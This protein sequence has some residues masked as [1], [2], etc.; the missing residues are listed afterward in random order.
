MRK[1]VTG[2]TPAHPIHSVDNAFAVLRLIA[3]GQRVRVGEVAKELN[4]SASTTS[5]LFAMLEYHG[6]A[7]KDEGARG[8]RVGS[9]FQDIGYKVL[10][11]AGMTAIVRPFLDDL[12]RRSTETVHLTRLQ[13][14]NVVFVNAAEG[15]DPEAVCGRTGA[16]LPAH[17]TAV[18][19]VL[20]ASLGQDDFIAAVGSERLQRWTPRSI[21]SRTDLE[22]QLNRVRSDGY[23]VNCGECERDVC[24]VAV[25]VRD[26]LGTLHAAMS[27][28]IPSAR[29]NMGLTSNLV[30]QLHLTA[31]AMRN[32]LR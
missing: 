22:R 28:S 27:I 15:S 26:R 29:F 4:L 9:A 13:A 32:R 24:A 23:A 1:R 31:S 8:Y 10:C 19:K 17:L 7:R 30:R 18:G 3:R 16:V 11:E 2:I 21:S 5:R 12:A 6:F 25:P 14:G 20:L